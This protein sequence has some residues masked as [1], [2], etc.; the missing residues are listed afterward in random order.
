[1]KKYRTIHEQSR[2]TLP[3]LGESFIK[4]PSQF[5]LRVCAV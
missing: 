5:T 2:I 1:M 4:K 3:F